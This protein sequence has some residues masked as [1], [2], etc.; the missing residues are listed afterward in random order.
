MT[1]SKFLSEWIFPPLHAIVAHPNLLS[2]RVAPEMDPIPNF[3][4]QPTGA[5][6]FR[7]RFGPGWVLAY[8]GPHKIF[9]MPCAGIL[10][11]MRD[12]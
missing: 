11:G 3:P 8:F 9:G 4:N 1:H 5:P 7:P 12:V 2:G 6:L 10:A